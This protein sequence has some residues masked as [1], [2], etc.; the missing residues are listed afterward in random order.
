MSDELVLCRIDNAWWKGET[1]D[2][3]VS[4]FRVTSPTGESRTVFFSQ[5]TPHE[6]RT[7][8]ENEL[9]EICLWEDFG[10]PKQRPS[11][12]GTRNIHLTIEQMALIDKISKRKHLNNG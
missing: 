6:M 9:Y 5:I 1:V 4:S 10:T 11:L 2:K 8:E 3:V 12:K 7:P